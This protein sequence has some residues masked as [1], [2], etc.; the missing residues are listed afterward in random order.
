[1]RALQ[2]LVSVGCDVAYWHAI[3]MAYDGENGENWRVMR[4]ESMAS[5]IHGEKAEGGKQLQCR[6]IADASHAWTI[7]SASISASSSRNRSIGARGTIGDRAAMSGRHSCH[8]KARA[9]FSGS[10]S[11]L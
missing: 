6:K 9:S 4:M 1:M 7:R 5:R 10:S 3:G 8:T 2:P 11:F